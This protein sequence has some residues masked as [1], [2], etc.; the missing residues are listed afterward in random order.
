MTTTNRPFG[1]S[2]LSVILMVVGLLDIIGGGLLFIEREDQ[3]VLVRMG[4][5]SDEIAIWS[6]VTIL[7][8]IVVIAVA[9][10][11]RN[12]SNFA[13]Y[14]IAFIAIVRIIALVFAVAS[15][16]K[17]DWYDALVPAVV[18]ALIAGY[19]L[20]DKNTEAWFR[21]VELEGGPS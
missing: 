2:F 20:F 17:G 21:E 13:R 3:S 16:A 1:I 10:A 11:L 9:A 5:S 14:L 8:G 6:I 12:G 19:L 15:Y 7:I 18:Y 4:G